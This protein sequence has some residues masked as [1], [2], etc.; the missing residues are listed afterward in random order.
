MEK[1]MCCV[2]IEMIEKNKQMKSQL[3]IYKNT[4]F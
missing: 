4:N 2:S 1:L 3:I